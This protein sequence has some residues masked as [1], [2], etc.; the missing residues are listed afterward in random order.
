M[1]FDGWTGR[2]RRTAQFFDRFG[3]NDAV[4]ARG[5]GAG[6]FPVEAEIQIAES[7]DVT[8]LISCDAVPN[9]ICALRRRKYYR[10]LD[11]AEFFAG[12]FFVAPE[13]LAV[14]LKQDK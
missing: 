10:A 8:R 14:L 5:I 9:D 7:N 2:Q 4:G 6:V 12:C 1:I 3:R 11:D 13:Q